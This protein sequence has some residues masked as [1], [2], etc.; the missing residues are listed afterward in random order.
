MGGLQLDIENSSQ[1][2]MVNSLAHL[3]SIQK[4]KK[5]QTKKNI[6]KEKRT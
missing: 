3:I 6:S 1:L 5:L 2:Y 4:K